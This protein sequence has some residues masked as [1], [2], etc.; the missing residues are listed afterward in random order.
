[1]ELTQYIGLLHLGEDLGHA[2]H[3]FDRWYKERHFISKAIDRPGTFFDATCGTGA[4]ITDLARWSGHSL[5]AYGS[6]I[7]TDCIAIGKKLHPSGTFFE[8]DFLQCPVWECTYAYWSIFTDFFNEE[9]HHDRPIE[10]VRKLSKIATHRLI[11]ATYGDLDS[12]EAFL[13]KVTKIQEVL[14]TAFGAFTRLTG[15]RLPGYEA[16]YFERIN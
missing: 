16:G 13:A 11:V 10:W 3:A 4:L 5:Q 12:T 14:P 15:E 8:G 7:D 9:D 2:E 1:M 6:D